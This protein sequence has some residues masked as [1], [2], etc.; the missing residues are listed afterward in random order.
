MRIIL[1]KAKDRK[2]PE[3][4][5]VPENIEAFVE[6]VNNCLAS[7]Y[8]RAHDDA[9][10]AV[11]KHIKD[12]TQ[13]TVTTKNWL[14]TGLDQVAGDY[15]PF[16]GKSLEEEGENLIE[17][18]RSCFDEAFNQYERETLTALEQLPS[19]LD[20][21]K[22]LTIPELIQKNNN[23]I[24]LYPELTKTTKYKRSTKLVQAKKKA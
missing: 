15:C 22:C 6:Q 8:Q 2:E 24:N 18:Y 20:D 5:Y 9:S 21:F 19:Q 16:C 12:K 4:L 14:K 3:L 17:I 10:E 13:N 1:K 7:T 23:N 11:E